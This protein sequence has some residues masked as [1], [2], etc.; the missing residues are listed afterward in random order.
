[1]KI[2]LQFAA[3]TVLG[4][5]AHGATASAQISGEARVGVSRAFGSPPVAR[6]TQDD[7]QFMADTSPARPSSSAVV[8]LNPTHVSRA[9][10]VA[11]AIA[12][13]RDAGKQAV[14]GGVLG[15]AV[16]VAITALAIK[17]CQ[18]HNAPGGEDMCGLGIVFAG[19]P[20]VAVGTLI[21][22]ATGYGHVPS[23][24]SAPSDR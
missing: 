12:P 20:A 2:R 7:S 21:G 15:A 19:I 24:P 17:N 14:I 23:A 8:V 10:T 3:L 9:D 13:P 11:S 6:S 1:M 22:A 16:G 4:S 5:F 18:S